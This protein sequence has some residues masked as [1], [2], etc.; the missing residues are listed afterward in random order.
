MIGTFVAFLLL[1]QPDPVTVFDGLAKRRAV[2][3]LEATCTSELAKTHPFWFLARNGAYDTG[4]FGWSA[5]KLDHPSGRTYVVFTTKITSEDIGDQVFELRDGKLSAYVDEADPRGYRVARHNLEVRF[6]P[7]LKRAVI[8]DV[9]AFAKRGEGDGAIWFRMGSQYRVAKIADSQGTAVPFRQAGGVVVATP[10]EGEPMLTIDYSATVDL[11]GYAASISDREATLTNDYWYPMTGRLPAPYDLTVIAPKGWV[12]VGQ[13]E[14]LETREENG[15]SVSRFKMDLPVTFYSLSSAPYRTSERI[16]NG[17]KYTVWSLDMTDEQMAIQ[18]AIMPD[19]VEFYEKTF[20]SYPFSR[21]GALVSPSYG[22]GAL[23][24]YSYATYGSGWLPAID[25]HEPA[26]TWWGGLISNGYLG[27][28]WNESFAVFSDG[29]YW[30]EGPIGNREEKRQAFV[31]ESSPDDGYARV[32]VRVGGASVGGVATALGYGKGGKVLQML[33][34]EIGTEATV[35]A[36]RRWI[37][38]HPK[39]ELGEWRDFQKVASETAGRPLDRFFEQWLDRPGWIEIVRTDFKAEGDRV[40]V[41]LRQKLPAYAFTLEVLV[42]DQAG[43]RKTTRVSVEPDAKGLFAFSVPTPPGTRLVSLDPWRKLLMARPGEKP[44]LSLAAFVERA[45][46]YVD[47]T[48]SAVPRP[49]QGPALTKLPE[50]LDGIVLVGDPVAN[51]RFKI[52]CERAGFR[53]TGTTLR[54][55]EGTDVTTIDLRQGGAAAIVELAGGGRCAVWLGKTR[56]PFRTGNA[57]TAVVDEFGRFLRGRT[58]PVTDGP[59]AYRLTA[60]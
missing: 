47:P 51:A 32:P 39:G 23:E 37:E 34:L 16:V 6:E 30:R 60:R 18:T 24:A 55:G 33:E 40:G 52:L 29:L 19:V 53:V 11:P 31:S 7:A 13:G 5:E 35:R 26:H 48:Q 27:S 36:M 49:G 22:G 41:Q 4:R 43:A 17:R 14:P 15:R 3:E 42:E 21:W 57:R 2:A 1:L 44:P 10:P 38:T 54:Y 45:P 12:T 28:L 25:A 46:V 58:D 8:R 56:L 59:L 9:A 20:A 50:N